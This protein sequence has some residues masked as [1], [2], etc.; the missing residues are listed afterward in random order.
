MQRTPAKT[1]TS[2]PAR[3]MLDLFS[4]SLEKKLVQRAPT[5]VSPRATALTAMET[6]IRAREACSSCGRARTES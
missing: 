3:P 2:P 1:N 4:L 6:Q 5:T